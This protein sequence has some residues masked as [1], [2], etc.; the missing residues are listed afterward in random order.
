[1]KKLIILVLTLFSINVV[2]QEVKSEQSSSLPKDV[3]Y[4]INGRLY[5]GNDLTKIPQDSILSVNVI[6][7]DT[8]ISQKRYEAQIFVLLKTKEEEPK[9][10]EKR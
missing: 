4:F 1:M 10:L 2:A 8:T 6:R 3:A 5:L 9:H 7:R